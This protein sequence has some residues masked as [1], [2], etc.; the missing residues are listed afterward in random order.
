[1]E[2]V[3]DRMQLASSLNQLTARGQISTQCVKPFT[4]SVELPAGFMV[5]RF[6]SVQGDVGPSLGETTDNL[7]PPPQGGQEP[8]LTHVKDLYKEACQGCMS[9]EE[10]LAMAKLLRKYKDVFNSGDHD[11]GQTQAV[12]HETPLAVGTIPIQ[13]PTRRLWP[14][15]EKEVSRQIRDFLD[16]GL[17][18]PAHGAWS[19][20][21]IFVR[22]KDGISWFCV[23]YRKLN[24]ITIQDAYPLPALISLW[25]PWS[26]ASTS[27]C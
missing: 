12:C 9:N 19:S 7:C 20:P 11:A 4:E 21:V 17:I 6:H 22:K 3:H 1:M 25:T 5:N 18:E 24:S 2:S 10:R 26:V 16:R 13:Q 8:I 14:E 23:D 15:Q 27:A